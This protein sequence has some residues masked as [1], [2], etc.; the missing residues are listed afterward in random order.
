MEEV[1][2]LIS[3]PGILSFPDIGVIDKSLYFRNPKC[4]SLTPH[5]IRLDI[6]DIL[7]PNYRDRTVL[8]LLSEA[9]RA[10]TTH[11]M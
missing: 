3:D 9:L 6:T 2:R 5:R 4:L 1:S 8:M 10:D 11:G 7:R